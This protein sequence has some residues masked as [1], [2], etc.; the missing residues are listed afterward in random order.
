MSEVKFKSKFILMDSKIFLKKKEVS[1]IY[2]NSFKLDRT[3]QLC[4]PIHKQKA[5][6]FNLKEPFPEPVNVALN[7]DLYI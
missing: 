6:F 2:M 5:S 3:S 4:P 1:K 7:S